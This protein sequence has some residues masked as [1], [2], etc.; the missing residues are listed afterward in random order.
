VFLP[1]DLLR[2]WTYSSSPL[3]APY[4]LLVILTHI[5]SYLPV[6]AM[7]SIRKQ[8]ASAIKDWPFAEFPEATECVLRKRQPLMVVWS[9]C[10][11]RLLY[12]PSSLAGIKVLFKES[13]TADGTF[14]YLSVKP[15]SGKP[16]LY[17]LVYDRPANCSSLGYA[18]HISLRRGNDL[19]P[20]HAAAL[21]HCVARL[22]SKGGPY[23]SFSRR[24]KIV[25][26][27]LWRNQSPI[28]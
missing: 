3:S 7:R 2:G 8:E 27:M 24:S 12:V 21:Y 14:E 4:Q 23:T 26:Q 17:N 6:S 10:H 18:A 11:P 13:K 15:R 19:Y 22:Y 9:Y 20:S 5:I 1:Q 28:E 25:N 16:Q